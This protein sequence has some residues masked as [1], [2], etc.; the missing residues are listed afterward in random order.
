MRDRRQ[1]IYNKLK[2]P[3]RARASARLSWQVH[4]FAKWNS[5][6]S[7]KC[8]DADGCQVDDIGRSCGERESAKI[9]YL[10]A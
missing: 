7:A 6:L 3:Q 1:F 4:F 8:A 5:D 9:V 10:Y 2:R